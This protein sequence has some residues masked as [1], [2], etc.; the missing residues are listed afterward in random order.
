MAACA[1]RNSSQV[2]TRLGVKI[3]RTTSGVARGEQATHQSLTWWS[4]SWSILREES[5][6]TTSLSCRKKAYITCA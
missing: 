4:K 5:S 3:V 6:S 2:R 1:A